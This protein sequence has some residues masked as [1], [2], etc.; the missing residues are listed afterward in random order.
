MTSMSQSFSHLDH[1]PPLKLLCTLYTHIICLHLNSSA[2][3]TLT[4]SAPN[5]TPLHP[6]HSHHLPPLKLLCTLYTRIICLHLNSSAPFTLTPSAST[7]LVFLFSL[8]FLFPS[9]ISVPVYLSTL[10]F[11]RI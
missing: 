7:R 5:A 8:V 10:Y 11:T 1:L 6:L 2:P 3:F 9:C 4:P